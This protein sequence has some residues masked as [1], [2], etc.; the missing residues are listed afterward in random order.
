MGSEMC[1]RDRA[2]GKNLTSETNGL[3]SEAKAKGLTAE[4]RAKGFL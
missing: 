4:A 1:I 3:T 2:E